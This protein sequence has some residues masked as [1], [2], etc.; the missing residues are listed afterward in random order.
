MLTLG[1]FSHHITVYT[2]PAA[3]LPSKPSTNT[4]WEM[5]YLT[6]LW[7]TVCSIYAYQPWTFTGRTDAEAEAPTLWPHDAKSQLM[8][9]DPDAGKDWGLGEKRAAED[10][11]VGWHH[12]LNGHEF[13]Q[14]LGDGVEQEACHTAAHGSPRVRNNWVTELNW[15]KNLILTWAKVLNSFSKEDI[16]KTANR[17]IIRCSTWLIIREMQIKTAVS[18]TAFLLNGCYRRNKK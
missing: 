9:K 17:Y 3:A 7:S 15:N 5:C 18:I 13:E 12:R 4:R 14:A 6:L 2:T 8:G 1:Y 11:V 10:E 16:P